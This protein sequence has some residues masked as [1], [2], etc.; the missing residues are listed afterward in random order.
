MKAATHGED[1]LIADLL[2]HELVAMT[3]DR[4]ARESGN[5]FVRQCC[6]RRVGEI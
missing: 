3:G 4:R 6:E 2:K 5:R 1:E